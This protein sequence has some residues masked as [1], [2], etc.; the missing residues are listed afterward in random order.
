MEL[1]NKLNN[2]ESS[3]KL[4][5]FL[6]QQKELS[7]EIAE[8]EKE[9]SCLRKKI[10]DKWKEQSELGHVFTQETNINS[11][12]ILNMCNLHVYRDSSGNF[13]RIGVDAHYHFSFQPVNFFDGK[14][15]NDNKSAELYK[16]NNRLTEGRRYLMSV[17]PKDLT[18]EDCLRA[19]GWSS[20]GL[21][22]E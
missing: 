19:F 1:N 13:Y 4:R 2:K 8:L 11:N 9:I 12:D 7:D 10:T 3:D 16:V 22:E 5:I 20:N 17:H 14:T 18:V 15:D 6:E 21:F